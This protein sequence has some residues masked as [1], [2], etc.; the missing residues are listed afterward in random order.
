MI[1]SIAGLALICLIG[2]VV[3]I[4]F[5]AMIEMFEQIKQMRIYLDMVDKPTV[6]DLGASQGLL[7]SGVGLPAVLDSTPRAAVLFLS[8]KCETCRTLAAALDGGALP[9]HLWLVVVP[10]LSG[11]A[12][13]FLEDFRLYGDRILVDADHA[14]TDAIGLDIT[15]SAITLEAGRMVEAHT[16]P[17][18]RQL[19]ASLP[20]VEKKRPMA[21]K[22]LHEPD[23]V[24]VASP[25]EVN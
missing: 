15:P 6:L 2:A 5:G 21:R 14:I 17:T 20:M 18:V 4:Q 3:F 13:Q 16:V 19:Y 8:N 11:D 7:A 22:P 12:S 25:S 9:P 24:V 23:L 1:L 10:V